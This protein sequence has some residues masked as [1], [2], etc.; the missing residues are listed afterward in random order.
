M[1]SPVGGH[2]P[3]QVELIEPIGG[4]A[5]ATSPGSGAA[6]A[7][8]G[9]RSALRRR[10]EALDGRI[11]SGRLAGLSMWMAIWVLSWPILIESLLNS[12]VG[13]VDTML[14]AGLSESATDAI[15]GAAYFAWFLT[16][17][18]SSVGV[19]ATAM[20][21]RAMGK[22]RRAVANAVVGQS[23]LLAAVSGATVA[24][25]MAAA[26]PEFARMLRLQGEAGAQFVQYL[27]I[28]S[29]G[30]PAMSVM[31][32]GLA[33]C[34][35]AGDTLRPMVTMILV[36]VVNIAMSWSLAGVDIAVGGAATG[37]TVA[38]RVLLENPFGFDLGI[39]GIA[40]GTVA[41]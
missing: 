3:E 32:V 24:V 37:G 6:P 17:V 13:L 31:F 19:G 39:A 29:L 40:W 30:V 26:A 4:E 18:A 38:R 20:V 5:T 1:T 35:G 25:L 33:C 36:N 11:R 27:R 2:A 28:V 41:A 22:G 8:A 10:P 23:L 7:Q 21:S 16:L 34:R 12:L 15:G 14:A 9:T